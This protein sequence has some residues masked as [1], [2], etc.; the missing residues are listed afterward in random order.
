MK[1]LSLMLLGVMTLGVTCAGVRPKLS[2]ITINAS[3]SPI[4]VNYTLDK[5]AVVTFAVLTNGVPVGY[6]WTATGWRGDVFRLVD[7]GPHSFSWKPYHKDLLATAFSSGNAKIRVKA[8][9][10]DAPPDYVV[11]DLTQNCSATY[12]EHADQI[13]GGV[14]TAACKFEKLV[15]RKIP[16]ALETFRMGAPLDE[17][18]RTQYEVST[19]VTLTN[20]YYLG[21]F[22]LTT[23]QYD[24]FCGGSGSGKGAYRCSYGSIRPS[25]KSWPADGHEVPERGVIYNVRQGSNGLPFDL[26]TRAQ[27]EFACRAGCSAALYTGE[28]LSVT[29]GSADPALEPI[30]WY[31]YNSAPSVDKVADQVHE[32]GLKQPNRWGLYDMIGNVWEFVLDYDWTLPAGAITEPTGPVSGTLRVRCGGAYDSNPS[33][34]RSASHTA[35]NPS[36]SNDAARGVNG[37]NNN[38]QGLRLWLPA[39][40][41]R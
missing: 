38:N 3:A 8:W 24:R 5:P 23:G 40:A 13:A 2:G 1:K 10:P 31:G 9:A 36:Y 12:F 32:V 18:G 6:E 41:F 22:E 30:A 28:S 20:D 21:V 25:G 26:P 16:A 7:A 11:F 39:K 17:K 4:R 14:T 29:S 34:C 15:M 33:S 37:T 35:N 27:W 19:L